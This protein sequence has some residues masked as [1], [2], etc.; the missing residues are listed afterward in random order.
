MNSGSAFHRVQVKCT[1]YF[2]EGAYRCGYFTR[3]GCYSPEQTDFLA[4]YVIPCD[5][6]YIIPARAIKP[7]TLCLNLY[8]HRRRNR[9]RYEQ[10]RE[11]WPLLLD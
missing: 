8:P 7:G 1:T 3:L 9:G 10:F 11:A 2:G 4:A 5:A 6:W